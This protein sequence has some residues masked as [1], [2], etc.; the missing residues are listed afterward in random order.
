MVAAVIASAGC[1]TSS[2]SPGAGG[3]G[4]SGGTGSDCSCFCPNGSDCT[5]ATEPNPCGV[6]ADG[7]PDACGCPVDCS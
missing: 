2:D 7:I 6:D 1:F 5:N 3:S 4:G